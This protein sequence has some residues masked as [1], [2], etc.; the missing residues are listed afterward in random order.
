VRAGVA[1]A[2]QQVF[3]PR[4]AGNAIGIQAVGFDLQDGLVVVL[5]GMIVTL[6]RGHAAFQKFS[7][8][9]TGGFEFAGAFLEALKIFYVR[10]NL[11]FSLNH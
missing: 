2:I 10:R 11:G 8:V 1:G 4:A 9:F 5:R 7:D 6:S 3:E